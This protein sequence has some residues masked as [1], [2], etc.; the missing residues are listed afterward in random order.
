MSGITK[1]RTPFWGGRGVCA[2]MIAMAILTGAS[3][4]YAEPQPDDRGKILYYR[5]P[6]GLPDKSSVPKKDGMGMDYIPVY[7]NEEKVAPGTVQISPERIQKL[8]VKTEVIG[9]RN[10][11]QTVR[12]VG[13]VQI[14]ERRQTIISPRFE[15]WV[16]K[17]YVD[18]TGAQFKKG[19]PLFVFYSPDITHIEAEYPFAHNIE[20]MSASKQAMNGTIERL[21]TLAIPQEE[22]DRLKRE[23]TASYHITYRAPADGT[24][25]EKMA[26]EGMKFSP[27]D[28]LYRMADLSNV[29]VMA[30]IYEQDLA[31]VSVGQPAKI[32][33]NA[34]PGKVFEGQVGF[35][36]PNINKDTRTAKIRIDLPN[37]TGELRT[38]MYANVELG[39]GAENSILA[40]PTSAIL[41]S[42]EKQ[43][44]LVDLGDGR[45]APRPIKVG[46]RG[47]DYAEILDGLNEGDRVV[48]SANFLIDA[49]SNLR[50]ALQ[51]F[52]QPEAKP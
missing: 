31:R 4:V 38:D 41:N 5:N 45:F 43:I 16:E 36:Y 51:G 15:G 35:I 18:A 11:A 24:V 23:K 21:K 25:M 13:T 27:G 17:L 7:E 8:G 40:V 47:G 20:T 32:T 46:A 14:D 6:M 33:I 9:K 10:L 12:A 52:S 28:M 1:A 19:D 37:P 2:F 22:I 3:S 48:T 29:W 50:A 34:Y 26:V 30:D 49:E 44:V 39:S 42:G